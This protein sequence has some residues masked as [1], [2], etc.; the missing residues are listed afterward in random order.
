MKRS[1]AALVD[2]ALVSVRGQR[3]D[4]PSPYVGDIGGVACVHDLVKAELSAFVRPFEHAEIGVP[5]RSSGSWDPVDTGFLE[6]F[7]PHRADRIA[8]YLKRVVHLAAPI[9]TAAACKDMKLSFL[10]GDS[11][12]GGARPVLVQG[13][14]RRFV[15]KPADP[16][17]Y[18]LLC[19]VLE[20]VES[21]LA[22]GLAYPRLV[23]RD[24]SHQWQ[25]LP[26]L[27]PNICKDKHD[28]RHYMLRL[29]AVTAAAYFLDLTDI[30]CENL[31]SADCMPVIVD[32]EC[33]FSGF[34][35]S[36]R[37]PRQRLAE[38]GLVATHA[39]LSAILG[40]N[41]ETREIGGH[42]RDGKFNYLRPTQSQSHRLL[43]ADGSCSDPRDHIDLISEGF[44]RALK[45][46]AAKQRLLTDILYDA[47][48]RTC[49][50]RY[51]YRPTAHYKCCLELLFAPA[52][53][54]RHE[55]RHALLREL[56]KLTPFDTASDVDT[57][58]GELHDLLNGD[59][60]YF[61]LAGDVPMLVDTL[62]RFLR[63][64]RCIV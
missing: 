48:Y 54:D 10:S 53:T 42:L 14:D 5:D 59:I 21:G 57:R 16:R 58:A 7:L 17:P 49:E 32:A 30:H 50:T 40:G 3:V 63:E 19:H 47:R 37:T 39:D 56:F 1:L 52:S 46:M 62:Q 41:V 31:I 8:T 23:V 60:P 61:H 28:E 11:H 34:L 22:L 15:V 4:Q 38:T 45:T 12:R 26:F 6:S 29:G 51:V 2:N 43:R 64:G 13:S 35:G 25:V 55:M 24:A 33:M 9:I 27:E 36:A 44:E 18:E 20:I